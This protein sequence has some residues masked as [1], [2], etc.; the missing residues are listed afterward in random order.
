M[1]DNIVLASGVQ[2]SESSFYRLDS[3]YSN[4]KILAVLAMCFEC[5]GYIYFV[6]FLHVCFSLNIVFVIPRF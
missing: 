5:T 1:I 4:Y 2:H 6:E 3:F